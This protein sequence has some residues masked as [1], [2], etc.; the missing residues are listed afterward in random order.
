[1]NMQ[2]SY[3]V[4]QRESVIPQRCPD[5]GEQLRR[6]KRRGVFL[7]IVSK[8]EQIQSV[9]EANKR[10]DATMKEGKRRIGKRRRI[11]TAP[12]NE[13]RARDGRREIER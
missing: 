10:G 7:S 1:M 4:F 8:H 6:E 13:Q 11:L 3:G 5:D 2:M 12:L 9:T